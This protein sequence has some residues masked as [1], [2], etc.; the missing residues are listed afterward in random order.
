MSNER[1]RTFYDERRRKGPGLIALAVIG[2]INWIVS[3][4]LNFSSLVSQLN[5]DM[6]AFKQVANV[7]LPEFG[8]FGTLF[9]F[10]LFSN[11]LGVIP[12]FESPTMFPQVPLGC[13]LVT[14]AYYNW[15]GIRAN[16][17]GRYLAHFAGPIPAM[18]PLMAPIELISHM[19]RPLSLTVRLFANMYAGEQV[20]LVFIS[21]AYLVA[22]ALFMGLHVFVGFLQAY[23]FTL[24]TMTYVGQAV[25]HEH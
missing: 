24:L 12:G 10:I 5:I 15:M 7:L 19:A 14:F 13:A 2:I 4:V 9:V 20:T 3:D 18:A 16:G 17:I 6:S 23:V 8:L 21:L 22:P 25:A 1:L 11:L